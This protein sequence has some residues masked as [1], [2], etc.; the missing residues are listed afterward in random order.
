[1][2]EALHQLHPESFQSHIDGFRFFLWRHGSRADVGG[3]KRFVCERKK[4]SK[5]EKYHALAL[6]WVSFPGHFR[7]FEV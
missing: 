4:S 7:Y 2:T 5:K 6:L 1:M 3:V